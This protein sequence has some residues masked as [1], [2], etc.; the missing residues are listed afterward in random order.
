[1]WK[2][3]RFKNQAALDEFIELNA[4]KIAYNVIY[5]NNGYAVEY[6][7]LRVVY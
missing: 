5:I 2:I 3:K 1:M 7:K 4:H 6:K